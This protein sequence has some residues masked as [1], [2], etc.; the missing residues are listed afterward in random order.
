MKKNSEYLLNK[1][2]TQQKIVALTCYDYPTALLEEQAG[3]DMM[4]VGD[5][6]GTNILGY[7]DETEVTMDDIAHHLK[8]VRRGVNQ[9]YILADLPYG[10]YETPQQA[11]DNAKIL[12]S[13]GADGVKLEGVREEV[14]KYLIKH[15]VEVCGHLGLL[16]QTQQKK[17]VQGKKFEQAKELIAGAAT[18]EQLGI[19]MLVLELI[20]E[21]LGQII[22][23][24]SKVPTIGIGSGRFTDGQVLIVND[25]LGITPYKL[26]LA[27]KYQDYQTLTLDTIEKYR[28]EVEQQVF[29]SEDNVRHMAKDEL[30]QLIAWVNQGTNK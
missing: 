21:E 29:P 27:K 1:K 25:I 22:S 7:Q 9:S 4:F 5:S 13:H 14:V 3:V 20:P 18:L 30:E 11:L 2:Q 6:V 8:A 12:I 16:P 15:N 24:N 26:K 10:S 28:K 17:I 19:F 23:Q